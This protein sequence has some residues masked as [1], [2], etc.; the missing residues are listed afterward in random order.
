MRSRPPSSRADAQTGRDTDGPASTASA[1]AGAKQTEYVAFLHRHP[2]ATDAYAL[3]FTT[4]VREDYSLQIDDLRNVDV[5]I[6]MLDNDFKRPD[7]DRYVQRFRTLNPEI[8]ILGDATTPAEARE[9]TRLARDLVAEF[10][11]TTLIIVPKC[12]EA[13]DII[14]EELVVGYAM[15]YG[16]THATDISDLAAWRGRRVHLLGA[17]PPKQYRVIQQLTQPTLASDLPADI[18]GLDWNGPQKVA[19]KGQY[20]NPDGWQAADALSIRETVNQSLREIKAY[21]KA[22]GVWPTQTPVERH[23]PAVREPDAP[24]FA[25]N[26]DDIT[27]REQLE[28]AIVVKYDTGQTFAYRNDTE[29]AHVE[30]YEGLFGKVVDVTG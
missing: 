18:V 27:D 30:Y 28:D 6:L 17:S 2:F 14:D 10:P 25:A 11:E 7:V 16:D 4:G 8:A 24:L 23:G 20:W 29:R 9:Y 13:L 3:G 26:G 1:I 15:G 21:W 19:Y 12:P 5:P 22:R